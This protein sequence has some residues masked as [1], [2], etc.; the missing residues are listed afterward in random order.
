MRF[1]LGEN[2]FRSRE[3]ARFIDVEKRIEWF[4]RP[5]CR[6][7]TVGLQKIR[8][9]APL[10]DDESMAQIASD[11]D[12][13][14]GN[15]R[16]RPPSRARASDLGVV[17]GPRGLEAGRKIVR[18]ER[19]V[20]WGADRAFHIREMRGDPIE[21]S[22]NP[23]KWSQEALHGVGDNRDTDRGK[24][25]RI[26]IGAQNKAGAL[27]PHRRDDAGEQAL[28]AELAKPLVAATHPPGKSAREHDAKTTAGPHCNPG[29]RPCPPRRLAASNIR[30][31]AVRLKQAGRED[32][33]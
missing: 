32:R 24:S 28:S 6:G 5:I 20:G 25:G 9:L 27:R 8:D 18:Q 13:P 16:M 22:E 11:R 26:A 30:A 29:P 3:I 2:E 21:R 15:Q 10:F 31:S 33:L 19:R 12:R 1:A 4:G 23:R 14:E 17:F 7:A